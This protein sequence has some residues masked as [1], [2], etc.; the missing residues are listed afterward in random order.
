MSEN[1]KQALM[2]YLD[3]LD[4]ALMF[5]RV[6]NTKPAHFKSRSLPVKKCRYPQIEF[7]N[8]DFWNYTH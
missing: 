2:L 8:D 6:R 1:V 4:K 3:G 7:D 5:Q